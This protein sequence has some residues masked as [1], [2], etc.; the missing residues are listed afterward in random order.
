MEDDPLVAEVVA[1]ALQ[2]AGCDIVRARTAD[3][4]LALLRER[5][6]APFDA[7]FSDIVMPGSL[8]GIDL[9]GILRREQPQLP[10]VLAS[11]YSERAPLASDVIVLSKPYS[12]ETLVRTL[13]EALGPRDMQ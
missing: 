2:G 8:S 6:G 9:A 12:I 13:A 7:V 4:A 11:G 5:G 10:V 3:E 1:S